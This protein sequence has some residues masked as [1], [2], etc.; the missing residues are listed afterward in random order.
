MESAAVPGCHTTA[1]MPSA[2]SQPM[3]ALITA[4]DSVMVT[5][6]AVVLFS[7]YYPQQPPRCSPGYVIPN[8]NPLEIECAIKPWKDTEKD[9]ALLAATMPEISGAMVAV[10]HALTRLQH[11]HEPRQ[12]LKLYLNEDE[13]NELKGMLTAVRDSIAKLN[14]FLME[15]NLPTVK[16]T[17]G[18]PG[19]SVTKDFVMIERQLSCAEQAMRICGKVM[20][21]TGAVIKGTADVAVN[22]G[23]PLAQTAGVGYL[24]ATNGSTALVY[25]LIK[26]VASL[27]YKILKSTVL[28]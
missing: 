24:V 11:A 21:N 16:L 20:T 6:Q 1:L 5:G 19:D 15:K 8:P 12:K 23:V 10:H 27:T 17:W 9:L 3:G 22:Y 14:G 28:K 13:Q 7:E 26:T 2:S 18:D 4:D 25:E